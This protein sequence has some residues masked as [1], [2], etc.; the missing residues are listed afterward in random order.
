MNIVETTT[1]FEEWLAQRIPL[2]PADVDHKHELMADAPFPF[3]RATFYRW[4]QV[5]PQLAPKSADAPIVLGIGDLHVENF[6]TWR[7]SEGRLIWGIND[8][9]EACPIPYTCDLV[10]LATS[11][12]LA[13]AAEHLAVDPGQASRAILE[14]YRETVASGPRPFV[15][16]E[17]HTALR[18]IAVERLKRPE[19]F[20]EKL[21]A[22]PPWHGKV[23]SSAEK[24]LRRALPDRD[25]DHHIVHRVSGLGSLGRRRFVALA[26]WRGG[27]VAREAK[28]L[29]E[30]AWYFA[31]PKRGK[32]RIQYQ[33]ILDSI[34]RCSD[35]FVHLR[36][37][38]IVRRLA[39]DCSRVELSSLPSKHDALRLLQAMG[40]ETANV[41][42]GS[43]RARTLAGDLK[44]RPAGWLD[45]AAKQLVQSVEDDWNDWR[46]RKR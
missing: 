16:A 22:M 40:A 29:T 26:E 25:L 24:A 14:G 31:N 19:Q 38:W 13:C 33:E 8:F 4:A 21:H 12:R 42:L 28:E 18:Q 17:H 6:G 5:W 46:K 37:R 3:L 45:K 7:D 44:K 43:V 2:I 35:P 9:D 1:R 30:S 27:S 36:G 20:W 23:P 10:R 11:A 34:P 15:L 32:S 39:P 41:H